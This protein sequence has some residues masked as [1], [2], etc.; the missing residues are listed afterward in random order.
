[1][2]ISLS[3]AVHG[4][5]IASAIAVITSLIY[6]VVQLNQNTE[7]LREANQQGHLNFAQDLA[8]WVLDPAFADTVVRANQSSEGLSDVEKLQYGEWLSGRLG[9]CEHVF[10]TKRNGNLSEEL[11]IPWVNYCPGWP[12]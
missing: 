8:V 1:M 3:N 10:Q 5:E 6:V 4:A 9:L 11:W 2:K 7:A 12:L